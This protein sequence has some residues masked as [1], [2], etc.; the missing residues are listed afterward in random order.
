[1]FYIGKFRSHH[2]KL[3]TWREDIHGN[4]PCKF[5]LH[6]GTAFPPCKHAATRLQG[7]FANTPCRPCLHGVVMSLPYVHIYCCLLAVCVLFACCDCWL[8][9]FF[10]L[11]ATCL[12]SAC[13]LLVVSA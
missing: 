3:F 11:L 10:L 9:A 5:D 6:E 12:L 1:M 7:C 13:C 2:V 4:S 8:S